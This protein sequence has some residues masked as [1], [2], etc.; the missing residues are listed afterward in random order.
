MTPSPAV[1]AVAL[2]AVL[3]G[4]IPFG[5]AAHVGRTRVRLWIPIGDSGNPAMIRARRGQ[6]NFV[7][8]V[9]LIL[10]QMAL[11]A[12]IGTPVWVIHLFGVALT[13]GSLLHGWRFAEGDA[14]GW[15]RAAGTALTLVPLVVGSLG[16]A[17]HALAGML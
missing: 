8:Y 2:Y 17:A 3:N 12:L 9:P 15:Q 7:K 14:P 1:L 4:L 16:L 6:A 10:L 11:M 13:L 5:L